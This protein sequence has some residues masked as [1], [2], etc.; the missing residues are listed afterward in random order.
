MAGVAYEESDPNWMRDPLSI[1]RRKWFEVPSGDHRFTT[2]DLLKLS[3]RE[4][5]AKWK[6]M[7]AEAT[8][9]PHFSVRGW[10]HT[11]YRDILRNKRVMDVGSGLGLDGITFAE[12]GAHLTYV[13]IIKSNLQLL[14]RLNEAMGL[15]TASYF[16]LQDFSIFDQLA[17]EYDVIWCQGSMINAPF[18]VMKIEVAELLKHL[19]IG[20]RWIE[21]AYPKERWEREGRMPFHL[22]GER[23]DGE[24]TPWVEWY[25]LEKLLAR[26]APAKFEVV[27]ALNFHNDDFNW[28]DLKRTA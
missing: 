28:F 20:G 24:G 21:L 11:L 9:G 16:Y 1:L 19:P 13:D 14:R 17:P 5:V 7:H 10:Y 25:D 22:W 4:L 3:D 27:L 8:T 6:Q 12:A 15:T 18:E 23:T 2:T 26:L